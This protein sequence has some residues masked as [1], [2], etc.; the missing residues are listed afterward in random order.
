M[1]TMQWRVLRADNLVKQTLDCAIFPADACQVSM[2]QPIVPGH[3]AR[4]S[5][6]QM[7]KNGRECISV[8]RCF[9]IMLF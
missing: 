8:I 2:N 6:L 3:W 5:L 1:E 4:R 9:G 7:A